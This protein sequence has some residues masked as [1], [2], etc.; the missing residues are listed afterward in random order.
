[1]HLEKPVTVKTYEALHK[2]IYFDQK[3]KKIYYAFRMGYEGEWE[4]GQILEKKAIIL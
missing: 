1:M 4:F 3:Q 2:R